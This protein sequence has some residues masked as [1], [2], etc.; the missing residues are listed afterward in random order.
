[1]QFNQ[2]QISLVSPHREFVPEL[3]FKVNTISHDMLTVGTDIE[4][5]YSEIVGVTPSVLIDPDLVVHHVL[6]CY[7]RDGYYSALL[8]QL[9]TKYNALLGSIK[10]SGIDSRLQNTLE[11]LIKD[12]VKN[13]LD[14][15]SNAL[16]IP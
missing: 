3:W 14:C 7:F 1:M 6:L 11:A 2:L 13:A 10:W 12:E 5:P 4:V 8:P 15:F 9:T 16:E